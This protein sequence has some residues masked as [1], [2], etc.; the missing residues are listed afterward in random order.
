MKTFASVDSL[1]EHMEIL[2]PSSMFPE[3][4]LVD[5]TLVLEETTAL[6]EIHLKEFQGR[7]S[8]PTSSSFSPI[9]SDYVSFSTLRSI[10][11]SE[12]ELSI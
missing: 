6:S 7:S 2:A 10:K 9:F 11:F 5:S 12:S 1:I 4:H 3:L 8:C